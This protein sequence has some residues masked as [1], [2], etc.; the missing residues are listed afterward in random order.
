M[1]ETKELIE[2][3]DDFMNGEPYYYV[4]AP[5]VY[6]KLIEIKEIL[7]GYD[8]ALKNMRDFG[9]RDGMETAYRRAK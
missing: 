9:Y 6:G 2:L 1:S 7:G 4:D 8:S 5:G 3:I